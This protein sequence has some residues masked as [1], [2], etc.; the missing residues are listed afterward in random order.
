[1]ITKDLQS[2]NGYIHV[3]LTP[4]QTKVNFKTEQIYGGS[5]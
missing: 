2:N 5:N 4:R 3:L 1:M